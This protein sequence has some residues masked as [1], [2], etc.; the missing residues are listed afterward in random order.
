MKKVEAESLGAVHT[1]THTIHLENEK[2]DREKS[3]KNQIAELV[4]KNKK[5][6]TLIALVITIIVLLIL[7]GVSIATLTGTNGILTQAQKSKMTTELS[8]YKEQLELYKTEKLSENREFLEST[9]TVGKESLTYNTQ[10]TGETGNIKTVIPSIKDEYIDKI[11]VIKGALLINTQ[12]KNEIEI[13]KSLGIAA[14]PYDIVNGELLSSNGNLLLMDDTGTLVIP[15]SVTKI[16]EGAFA[17]L[18]G[19]KTIIIP[20]TVKTIGKGAFRNNTTLE[21]VILQNGVEIISESA[22]YKC[23]NLQEVQMPESLRQIGNTSFYNT[24]IRGITIPSNIEEIPNSAFDSTYQLKQVNLNEGLKNIQSGAFSNSAFENIVI[25]ES[26]NTIAEGAF[27]GNKNLNNI[28]ISGKSPK[29]IYENGILT[30]K[31]KD[32]I[33]F[34]SDSYLKN[35]S[36]FTI[37]EGI[38]SFK[39]T[40]RQYDNITKI[41]IPSSCVS[42][43]SVGTLPK[44]IEN[45]E[46]KSGNSVY[47]T[48][49]NKKVMYNKTTKEII[50]CYSTQENINLKEEDLLIVGD[51]AFN[52]A[53]NAKSIILP[54]SLEQINNYSFGACSQ[55]EKLSMGAKVSKIGRGIIWNDNINVVEISDDNDNY[56]VQNG[57]LYSKDKTKICSVFYKIQGNFNVDA[58]ILEIT[59][60]AFYNQNNMTSINLPNSINKIGYSL[61]SCAA[62]TKIDIPNSVKEIADNAFLNCVNLSTININKKESSITGAPW[63]AP[64]GMKVVNWNG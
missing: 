58:G 55:L 5:G 53:I 8:S 6:I 1:H 40:L 32:S 42:G 48:L 35:I 59:D 36:T 23:T 20:G 19:L 33:I 24:A 60:G 12:D 57:I 9:L 22:F 49:D 46:I 62:L 26:V 52:L 34:I 61:E 50:V 7:A 2:I 3:C 54:D 39:I 14:N 31:N 38:T 27:N 41:V 4:I 37:P 21:R 30:N 64:K 28:T 43:I 18:E 10:P 13:A 15:D 45:I 56:V 47:A 63:G 16:G 11:E 17:N 29:F 44:K 25:P 51:D